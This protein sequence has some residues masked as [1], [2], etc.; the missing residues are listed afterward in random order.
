MSLYSD[1]SSVEFAPAF[2]GLLRYGDIFARSERNLA[3]SVIEGTTDEKKSSPVRRTFLLFTVIDLIIVF[4]FWILF[5]KITSKDDDLRKAIIN[6]IEHLNFYHSMF[7]NIIITG[8]TTLYLVVKVSLFKFKE[9]STIDNGYVL[10]YTLLIIHLII[11]WIETIFLECRVFP[12]EKAAQEV[13]NALDET[14]SMSNQR[15]CKSRRL[16]PSNYCVS[17]YG[18]PSA[19]IADGI[20]NERDTDQELDEPVGVDVAA[21][22]SMG[23]RIY[24]SALTLLDD[25]A[26]HMSLD[27]LLAAP[28]RLMV[29]MA[30]IK[31]YKCKLFRID[32]ILKASPLVTL[33]EIVDGVDTSAAWNPLLDSAN[34]LQLFREQ[35]MDIVHTIVADQIKGLVKSRDFV[36]LRK[37]G[38]RNGG[39][40]FISSSSVDHP[41]CPPRADRIRAHQHISSTTLIPLDSDFEASGTPTYTHF[42]MIV[43][44][45]LGGWIP[46]R[47]IDQATSGTLESFFR[48]LQQH[49]S[50]YRIGISDPTTRHRASRATPKRPDMIAEEENIGFSS[51]TTPLLLD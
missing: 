21:L 50:N 22:L 25:S 20:N 51:D 34:R 42:T 27:K 28:D 36:I 38:A 8:G 11:P 46:P 44:N 10:A 16:A 17:I 41:K 30:N 13:F 40:Y 12:Q 5:L 19:S 1:G 48:N 18:S 29:Q 24:G 32:G 43:C 14:R 49:I 23:H 26:W 7:D 6:D 35:S 31:G 3:A 9:S 45:D 39:G 4:I 33:R 47:V 15:A 37:W 2:P